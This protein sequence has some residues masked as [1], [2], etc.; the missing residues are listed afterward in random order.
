MKDLKQLTPEDLEAELFVTNALA[1]SEKS[2]NNRPGITG[3]YWNYVQQMTSI[4]G[5]RAKEEEGVNYQLF[6]RLLPSS[7]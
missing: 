1:E 7:R 2:M 3:K 6:N 4:R 5:D